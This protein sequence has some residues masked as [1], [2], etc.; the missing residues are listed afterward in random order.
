MVDS[1][2]DPTTDLL[3]V[4]RLFSKCI[5]CFDL[6]QGTK[7]C[8]SELNTLL[9]RLDFEKARLRN[10]AEHVGLVQVSSRNTE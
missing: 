7:N 8:G 10:W 6:Y 2:T 9:V 1:A 4:A 3:V 5:D